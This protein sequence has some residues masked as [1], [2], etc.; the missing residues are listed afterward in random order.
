MSG[1]QIDL[2]L[3][4]FGLAVLLKIPQEDP[5][6]PLCCVQSVENADQKFEGV[7]SDLIPRKNMFYVIMFLIVSSTPHHC[8]LNP[9][10]YSK[11][12]II[13]GI[14]Q[15]LTSFSGHDKDLK[16]HAEYSD[17]LLTHYSQTLKDRQIY[18]CARDRARIHG[19]ILVLIIDSYDKAKVCL[20]RFPFQR[21]PKKPIYD[22]IR[23]TLF[24]FRQLHMCH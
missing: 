21:T 6:F 22:R 1:L 8:Y 16:S 20:P 11:V 17:R 10:R 3:C 4:V 15:P 14:P 23:R 18:W 2:F 19:D 7:F 12:W 24:A 13:W 5:T 9:W